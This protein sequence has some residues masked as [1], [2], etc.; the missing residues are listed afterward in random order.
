V[1]V[2]SDDVWKRRGWQHRDA[3]RSMGE[4]PGGRHRPGTGGGE[5]RTA[6]VLRGRRGQGRREEGEAPGAWAGLNEQC[7]FLFIQVISKK[8]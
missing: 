6:G 3:W 7:P 1:G 2:G 4:G 5:R 8:T